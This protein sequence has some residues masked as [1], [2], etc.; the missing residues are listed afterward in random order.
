MNGTD[1]VTSMTISGYCSFPVSMRT[2]HTVFKTPAQLLN[3]IFEIKCIVKEM[4]GRPADKLKCNSTATL[5]FRTPGLPL[6]VDIQWIITM[7]FDARH[8]CVYKITKQQCIKREVKKSEK[9][10]KCLL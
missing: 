1:H 4:N 5:S 6:C 10:Y 8:H 7:Q 9:I 3:E 2:N